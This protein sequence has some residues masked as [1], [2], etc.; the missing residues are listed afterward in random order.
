MHTLQLHR[1]R[2]DDTFAGVLGSLCVYKKNHFH[3][4]NKNSLKEIATIHQ[5]YFVK[6]LDYTPRFCSRAKLSI[7]FTMFE[8]QYLIAYI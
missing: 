7:I 1:L 6:I 8:T 2:G 4:Y 5:F 3:N